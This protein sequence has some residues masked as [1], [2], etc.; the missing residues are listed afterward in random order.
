VAYSGRAWLLI[1]RQ[2]LWTQ[3]SDDGAWA[4]HQHARRRALEL[5]AGDI[6]FV[7]LTKQTV[8]TPS[9]VAAV[10][11]ISDGG[12]ESAALDTTSRFYSYKVPFELLSEVRPRVEFPELV[13][14][15]GFITRKDR[16]G[17]FLQG[18]SAILL[19]PE[20][21]GVV[22]RA[23]LAAGVDRRAKAALRSL[24]QLEV[25]PDRAA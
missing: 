21:A 11:I 3:F 2:G 15:L 12:A 18:K 6:A 22:A 19:R 4:F 1:T 25:P 14:Y 9:A 7:Y 20:D 17:V 8:R 13:P 23:A 10:V 24:I 5:R 16:Y